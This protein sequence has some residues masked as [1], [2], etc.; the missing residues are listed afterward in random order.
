MQEAT[1][2]PS[3]TLHRLRDLTTW[4]KTTS[5]SESWLG[6]VVKTL[7]SDLLVVDE[8]SMIDLFLAVQLLAAVPAGMRLVLIG[9]ADQLPPVGPGL[10]FRDLL[11]DERIPR[12]RLKT[13]FRQDEDNLLVQMPIGLFAVSAPIHQTLDSSFSVFIPRATM[14]LFMMQSC[15]CVRKYY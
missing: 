15:R 5:A 1:G 7:E 12:V 11:D 3:Q 4:S 9:D 8:S 6:D 10:F 14:R 2:V 13:I